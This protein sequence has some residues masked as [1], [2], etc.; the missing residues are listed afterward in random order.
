MVGQD[1]V[2]IFTKNTYFFF[3]LTT[4]SK[5]YCT[6]PSNIVHQNQLV[7]AEQLHAS[8][9]TAASMEDSSSHLPGL[10]EA[11]E[12]TGHNFLDSDRASPCRI[13][14]YRQVKSPR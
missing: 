6:H 14:A 13:M 9:S 5:G 2:R 11:K 12:K 8:P 10:L 4:P 1:S 7:M 3:L